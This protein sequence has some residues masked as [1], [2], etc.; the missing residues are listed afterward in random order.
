[1]SV[2]SLIGRKIGMTSVFEPGGKMVGVTVLEMGPNQVVCRRTTERDGYDAVALS[3][4][5]RR[6]SRQRRP[7]LGQSEAAGL[8]GDPQFVREVR[9][10]EGSEVAVGDSFSV[11]DVFEVGVHVDVVGTSRGHGFQGTRKRHHF[12]YGPAS[13]GS[14]N[15][16]EPGSTGHCTTP[17]RVFKGKRMAGQM[18]NKRRTTRNL[19]VV[20]VDAERNLLLVAGAVPGWKTG[21]VLVRHAIAR[22]EPKVGG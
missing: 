15:Y 16:R 12:S 8:E 6:V 13:H 9:V 22:V 21:T 1:M 14:K 7:Q 11:A 10:A 3:F 5:R 20:G 2:T 4:G 17:G 19:R 18:G